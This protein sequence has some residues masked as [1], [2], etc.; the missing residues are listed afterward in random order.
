MSEEAE[1]PGA[2]IG[3]SSAVMAAGT[4]LSRVLG[5]VRAVV[6]AAALG[7][8]FLGNAFQTANTLPN[9][10]YMLLAGGVLNAV[11]VPQ[12]VRAMKQDADAGKAYADRL[13]TLTGVALLG[14]T[15]VALAA[16]PWLMRLLGPRWS[17]A[18]AA[19]ATAFAL[20]CLPQI[21]FYGLY[22]MVSQVLNARG[23]FGPMMW[24][25]ILNN[26]VAIGSG[27]AFIAV[28]S[29]ADSDVAGTLSGWEVALIAG[30]STL[31]VAAQAVVLL[32]VLRRVGYRFTPRF[33]WRGVGLSRA[34]RLGLWTLAL[35][36]VNQLAYALVVMTL[37][38][39]SKTAGAEYVGNASYNYAYLV[40]LLPHGI[41]AVSVVTALIPR[42]S[43]A[44]LDGR[45]DRVR[46]DVSHGLRLIGCAT[47]PAAAAF[48]ALGPELT[49]ALFQGGRVSTEAARYIGYILMAFAPGLVA[50]SAQY[51]VLRGFYA[52]EDT[53]TPFFL[54]LMVN[55]VLV[56]GTVLAPLVLADFWVAVGIAGSYSLAYV[57]GLVVGIAVLRRRLGGL[58][59]A[60]VLRTHVRLGVA[61][62]L[63]ALL[64]Y[65][66]TRAV[67]GGVEADRWGAVLAVGS[68]G[69]LLGLGYLTLTRVL[70]VREVTGLLTALTAR[71]GR[72]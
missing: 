10:V 40:L 16:A 19:L 67:A 48:V 23:S 36:A 17:D 12:L 18:E 71:L 52:M 11:F 62:G 1:S 51:L 54:A 46:G 24:A 65:L 49:T 42:M 22:T 55:L 13:L 32:P 39:T 20:W 2:G 66:V 34:G 28:A 5:F 6:F 53:R 47:V 38:A 7:T 25:P 69:A 59:G 43:A 26:V 72:R 31:G 44:A 64:A 15:A 41:V 45:R 4:L 9:S 8:A 58:D 63:P 14:I 3:R 57:L 33:D 60:R 21:L 27:L 56:T 35:V 37:N 29:V 68:G 61:A 30:G 50:F 70:H